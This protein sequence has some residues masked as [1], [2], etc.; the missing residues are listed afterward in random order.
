MTIPL[1][2]KK[3]IKYL[4][5]GFKKITGR[6]KLG[7]LILYRRGGGHKKKYRQVDF[8][9]YLWNVYGCILRCEYDPFRNI[10]INLIGYSNGI[11]V[12]NLAISKLSIGMLV[13]SKDSKYLGFGDTT[14]LNFIASG[15]Y[16]NSLEI[17]ENKG[18]KY[19]RACGNFAK[20]L[21]K[22]NKISLVRLRSKKILLIGL[23]CLATLGTLD[24]KKIINNT[25]KKASYFRYKGWRPFVRG[26]AMNPIDHPH[27]GGQGKTSGGRPSSSP[28]G[29]YTK[30]IKTSKSSF[31]GKICLKR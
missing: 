14:F 15:K 3:S 30:G 25:Y 8:N 31:Y 22:Y 18:V 29:K 7:Q 19:I 10:Y 24:T 13:I 17:C 9:K 23:G 27:G 1:F 4:S 11:L 21:I 16:I 12:Y 5:S 2:K 20:L 26:V 6:N 28:W